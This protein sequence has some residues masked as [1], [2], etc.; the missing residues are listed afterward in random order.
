MELLN[1]KHGVNVHFGLLHLPDAPL[2]QSASFLVGFFLSLNLQ[3]AY[4]D[5]KL[6]PEPPSTW[7]RVVNG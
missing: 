1:E 7:G 3:K 2:P 6:S 5:E 4:P